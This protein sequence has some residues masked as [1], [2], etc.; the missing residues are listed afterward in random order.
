MLW[1]DAGE[2]EV[3]MQRVFTHLIQTNNLTGVE[4]FLELG[5]DVEINLPAFA[6]TDP[7]T[8][9]EWELEPTLLLI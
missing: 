4:F 2:D 6:I 5:A 9:A 3:G 1:K 8:G 7:D